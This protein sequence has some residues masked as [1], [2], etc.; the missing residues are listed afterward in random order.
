MDWH[1]RRSPL[2]HTHTLMQSS[3]RAVRISSS[4]HPQEPRTPRPPSLLTEPSHR[5]GRLHSGDGRERKRRQPETSL[6]SATGGGHSR[7]PAA[8]PGQLGA[9]AAARRG[10]GGGPARAAPTR[11]GRSSPKMAAPRTAAPRTAAPRGPLLRAE[12][13]GRLPG[14]RAKQAGGGMVASERKGV[15]RVSGTGVYFPKGGRNR[16]YLPACHTPA[17]QK[18]VV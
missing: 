12:V 1:R 17:L 3:G 6:K 18:R 14:R 5:R 13:T 2:T 11:P 16:R 8:P 10:G 4:R 9:G 15:L 7:A